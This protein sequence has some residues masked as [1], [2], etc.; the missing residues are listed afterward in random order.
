MTNSA[1]KEFSDILEL[2][3]YFGMEPG[4]IIRLIRKGKVG[5]F[6]EGDKAIV[7]LDSLPNFLM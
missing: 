5:M 6:I 3:E 7:D 4:E 1:Y 2:S